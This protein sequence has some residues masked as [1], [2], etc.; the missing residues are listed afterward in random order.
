MHMVDGVT[1]VPEYERE[2]LM[3]MAMANDVEVWQ[4]F[5][6]IWRINGLH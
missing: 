2:D 4:S 3:E 1:L 6:R 5:E